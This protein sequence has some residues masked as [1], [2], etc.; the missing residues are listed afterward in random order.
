[1]SEWNMYYFTEMPFKE[2]SYIDPQLSDP[3]LNGTIFSK[4]GMENAFRKILDLIE[5]RRAF[6]YVR[7]EEDS[8]G[9]GKSALMA[10]VYWNLKAK[11]KLRFLPV[12]VTVHDFRTINQLMSRI[13]DTLVFADAT[14]IIKNAL[15]DWTAASIQSFILKRKRILPSQAAALSAILSQQKETL[16]WKYANIKRSYPTGP[17]EVFSVLMLMFAEAD[18]RRLV[19]FIDQFEE[20]VEYQHG[21]KLTQLANDLKDLYRTMAA[22]GNLS[23]VVTMH[24]RTQNL[25]ESQAADILSTYGD[26]MGNAATIDPLKPSNLIS[27]AKAYIEHYRSED[28]PKDLRNKNPIFPYSE[29]LLTYVS[30]H[31]GGNPRILIRVLGNMLE[32]GRLMKLKEIERKLLDN[33]RI[34]ELS[35]LGEISDLEEGSDDT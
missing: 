9:T 32:I 19:V 15:S 14:D 1:M 28:F 29:D 4:S 8:R 33:S 25:F 5:L 7:S 3:R 24:P 31:C 13:V 35:G 17:V 22:S 27:I 20:Y 11:E 10:A 12:W 6:C 34:Y 26:I 2:G 30:E 23:F 18:K 21:A 16:A